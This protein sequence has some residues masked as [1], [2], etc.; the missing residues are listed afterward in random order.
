MKIAFD[1]LPVADPNIRSVFAE[2][3]FLHDMVNEERFMKTLL[4][5]LGMLATGLGVAG[6]FLPL[7]PT[8]PFLL[9]AAWIF[10]RSSPRFHEWLL[11]HRILGRYIDDYT[12]QKGMRAKTKG[13]VLV[14]LWVTIGITM[15]VTPLPVW[16]VVLLGSIAVGVSLHI[17]LLRTLSSPRS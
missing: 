5:G 7:L 13:A 4:I 15:A 14:L 10:A 12:R 8:T 1:H 9:L 16:G 6:I 3:Y 2:V 11:N 17:L